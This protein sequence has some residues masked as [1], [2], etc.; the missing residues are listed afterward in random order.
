MNT[1]RLITITVPPQAVADEIQALREPLCRQYNAL[2]ALRYPPH[3]TLRTG[4]IVPNNKLDDVYQIFAEMVAETKPFTIH[5]GTPKYKYMSYEGEEH[6]FLYLPVDKAR[7]LCE[8]NR[9]LLNFRNYRKSD[10][11]DFD[12]HLTLLW[13]DLTDIERNNLCQ[14]VDAGAHPYDKIFS[15]ECRFLSFY[16]QSGETWQLE[17]NVPFA[18]E[19]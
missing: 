6:F 19:E 17:K 9:R 3:L 2:W 13:G 11:M 18:K 5:T 14:K 8:L 7:E 1:T 12:P 15:W 10:K 4:L 16:T